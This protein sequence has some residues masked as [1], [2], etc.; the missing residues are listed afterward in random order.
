VL[1]PELDCAEEIAVWE[2]DDGANSEGKAPRVGRD[3][4]VSL[5]VSTR[6]GT[7]VAMP[8]V[9]LVAAGA[10]ESTG[11]VGGIG[12]VLALENNGTVVG[13]VRK[14]VQSPPLF[15]HRYRNVGL[16]DLES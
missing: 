16:V 4:R 7:E 12:S 9:A 15:P 14:T 10:V 3:G 6:K 11:F 2:V 8:G 5:N 1:A 13:A